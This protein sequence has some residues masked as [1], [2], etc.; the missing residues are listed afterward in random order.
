MS[1]NFDYSTLKNVPKDKSGKS[2]K[3]FN[4]QNRPTFPGKKCTG[5]TRT[6]SEF[7]AACD[8]HN[9]MKKYAITGD[10]SE[11]LKDKGYFA[12]V[13]QVGDYQDA[14]NTVIESKEAFMTL[15]ASIRAR[16]Q[17]D[18]QKLHA[19]LGDENNRDEAI[20]LGIIPSPPKADPPPVPKEPSQ[21]STVLPVEPAKDDLPSK[22]GGS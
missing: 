21:P 1:L 7:A 14:L 4:Y 11:E 12:D 6:K 13:S 18:P 19:F 20:K 8:I 5:E 16:F 9:I 10:L 3:I 17:N 15:E 2:I 22:K